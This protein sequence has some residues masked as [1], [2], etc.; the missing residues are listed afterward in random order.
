M[1]LKTVPCGMK[2]P[3]RLHLAQ[4]VFLASLYINYCYSKL[5]GVFSVKQ[6]C[7]SLQELVHVVTDSLN[8]RV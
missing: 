1:N 2:N 3:F 5:H 4:T 7:P 6:I 8:T